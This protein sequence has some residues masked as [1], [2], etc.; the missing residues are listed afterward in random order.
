MKECSYCWNSFEFEK[1]KLYCSDECKNKSSE[2]SAERRKEISRRKRR[3]LAGK[4]CVVC[5]AK[6]SM[7]SEGN[8]CSNHH[9][10]KAVSDILKQIKGLA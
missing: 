5:K 4:S 1:G 7:Y 3:L 2:E 9:N 6:L 10:P 8:T